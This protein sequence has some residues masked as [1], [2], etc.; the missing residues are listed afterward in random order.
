MLEAVLPNFFGVAC[1][2]VHEH[3]SAADGMLHC[4]KCLGMCRSS[5][6]A[7]HHQPKDL[8]SGSA[9]GIEASQRRPASGLAAN[10]ASITAWPAA[11]PQDQSAPQVEHDLQ[12]RNSIKN[13]NAIPMSS[14]AQTTDGKL[15]KISIPSSSKQE[16]EQKRDQSPDSARL[17][18][19]S[20]SASRAAS[21]VAWPPSNG[22]I[23]N[24]SGGRGNDSS[25][26]GSAG[27]LVRSKRTGGLD[28]SCGCM[29]YGVRR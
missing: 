21:V 24:D 1:W 2:C 27:P 25:L 23:V 4:L 16:P 29:D 28:Y 8:Q 13:N 20:P 19:L 18:P 15:P 11:Q 7:A 6:S 14:T 5:L 9:D 12:Y 17:E 26:F 10:A 3:F 22:H